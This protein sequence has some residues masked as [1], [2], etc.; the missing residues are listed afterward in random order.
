MNHITIKNKCFDVINKWGLIFLILA[1]PRLIYIFFSNNIA[2]DSIFY[3]DVAENI[4]KGCGFSITNIFGKCEPIVGGYFP[5]YPF[6]IYL[7]KSIGLSNKFIPIIISLIT[8]FSLVYLISNLKESG[9][10]G[11]KIYLLSFFLGFSPI[12][13]GF[14][15]YILIE[16]VIYIFS[17]LLI[18]EI[19]NL[20][21]HPNKLKI[22]F[23]RVLIIAFLAIYFKPTSFI[24]FAPFFCFNSYKLRI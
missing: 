16:P 22:I 23:K 19:L 5:G 21:N 2:N 20:K 24:L 9:L 1:I 14:S 3:L 12:S 7:I 10:R 15:R 6:F 4:S 17:I 18:A 13:V 8:T 11:K